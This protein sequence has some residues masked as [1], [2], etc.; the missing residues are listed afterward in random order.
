MFHSRYRLKAETKLASHSVKRPK[1]RNANRETVRTSNISLI[2]SLAKSNR[3]KKY[4]VTRRLS[5]K[6]ISSI[7]QFTSVT[8][9]ALQ[10][11]VQ[12]PIPMLVKI[13]ATGESIV[14]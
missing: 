13:E 9:N 11:S 5:T 4:H 6:N 8:K 10:N 12:V 3:D 2:C 7:F 14:I 1:H